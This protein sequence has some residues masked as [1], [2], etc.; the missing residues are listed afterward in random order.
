MRH[1]ATS[2]G[3]FSVTHR[4]SLNFYQ[5]NVKIWSKH[6]KQWTDTSSWYSLWLRNVNNSSYLAMLP[7]ALFQNFPN[8]LNLFVLILRWRQIVHQRKILNQNFFD[9]IQLITLF[10]N[11]AQNWLNLLILLRRWR[12]IR[13][14]KM[15]R[16]FKPHLLLPFLPG[17]RY[18][19]CRMNFRL[20]LQ[21][22]QWCTWFI[23]ILQ[24]RSH[25]KG[26]MG[27]TWEKLEFIFLVDRWNTP[28]TWTYCQWI[29][30]S[31]HANPYQRQIPNFR[32][33]QPS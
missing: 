1:D 29:R 27:Q 33:S 13:Q 18:F 4:Q 17:Y 32:F 21:K 3:W 20:F 25:N 24:G 30:A 7:I 9:I 26:F 5:S 28:N 23:I 16:L 11:L 2:F 12:K 19:A 15:R 6:W 22:F 8:I 10:L 31:V 14:R